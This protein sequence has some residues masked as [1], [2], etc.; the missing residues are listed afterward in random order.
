MYLL[1]HFKLNTFSVFLLF[2]VTIFLTGCGLGIIHLFYDDFEMI[3]IAK[4]VYPFA[5]D[6]FIYYSSSILGFIYKSL[7]SFS[8]GIE[9]YNLLYLTLVSFS[10]AIILSLLWK[11]YRGSMMLYV[12]FLLF[13]IYFCLLLFVS[14][15]QFT[16][17]S[18]ILAVNSILSLKL[19]FQQESKHKNKLIVLLIFLSIISSLYRFDMFLMIFTI[20]LLGL[21]AEGILL[22]NFKKLKI[23]YLIIFGILISSLVLRKTEISLRTEEQNKFA[24]FHRARSAF[25]DYNIQGKISNRNK[26]VKELGW[27]TNELDF[28]RTWS[29]PDIESL[30]LEKLLYYVNNA[31]KSKLWSFNYLREYARYGLNDVIFKDTRHIL[32]M[33]FVFVFL[34]YETR[35]KMVLSVIIQIVIVFSVLLALVVFF[36]I[37]GSHV[38][39]PLYLWILL[40]VIST[41]QPISIRS[42]ETKKAD[43]AFILLILLFVI[44]NYRIEHN[45]KIQNYR[46][47]VDI[48]KYIMAANS[49]I[50]YSLPTNYP[51]YAHYSGIFSNYK[52]IPKVFYNGLFFNHPSNTAF[53]NEWKIDSLIKKKELLFYFNQDK[54]FQIDAF[55]KAF[56]SYAKKQF[57][58]IYEEEVISLNNAHFLK[59]Y[60]VDK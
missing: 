54:K 33:F 36:K 55:S 52:K 22:K 11:K 46:T 58:I 18:G 47:V 32:L 21:L 2:F 57:R 24:D 3:M 26:L 59:I 5:A 10:F 34:I 1:K 42:Y 19:V 13:L 60:N 6:S 28:I 14:N 44:Q 7:Y 49:E 8:S 29:F 37:P 12:L 38:Q 53:Q 43:F 17:A 39:L 9:W 45:T 35:K 23:L 4:G 51:G 30:Q 15:V 48:D 41:I 16:F 31:D 50:I 40:Y 25:G 20:A 27:T 56:R